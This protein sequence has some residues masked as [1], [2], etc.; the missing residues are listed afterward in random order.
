MRLEDLKPMGM[1]ITSEDRQATLILVVPGE[2][3]ILPGLKL[4]GAEPIGAVIASQN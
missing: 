1:L 2:V 4:I 3:E